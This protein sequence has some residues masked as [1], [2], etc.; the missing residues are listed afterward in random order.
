MS[1]LSSTPKIRKQ[2]TYTVADHVAPL[3][4]PDTRLA[5]AAILP[6]A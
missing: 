5:V 4:A 3:F 1:I 2:T 6:P